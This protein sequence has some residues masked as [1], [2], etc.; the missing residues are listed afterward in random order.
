MQ[1]SPL[2]AWI[3]EMKQKK[4]LPLGLMSDFIQ[5]LTFF[6]Q[7]LKILADQVKIFKADWCKSFPGYL[8]VDLNSNFIK[9]GSNGIP[10]AC[11]YKLGQRSQLLGHM[12][13]TAVCGFSKISQ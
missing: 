12:T 2:N 3:P 13:Q 9:G 10:W 1:L 4:T 8:T 6:V 7:I 11:T 5:L